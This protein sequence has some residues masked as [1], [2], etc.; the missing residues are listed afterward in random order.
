MIKSFNVGSQ[1]H[2]DFSRGGLNKAK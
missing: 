2:V 1:M